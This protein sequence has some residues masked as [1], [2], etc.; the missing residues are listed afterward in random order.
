M[1]KHFA[2]IPLFDIQL[3]KV[4]VGMTTV[5]KIFRNLKDIVIYSILTPLHLSHDARNTVL[6]L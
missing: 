5:L 4:I 2:Y 1:I 6:S 3:Y